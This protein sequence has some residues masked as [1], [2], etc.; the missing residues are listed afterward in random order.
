MTLELRALET[1]GI[2]YIMGDGYPMLEITW[3]LW[4]HVMGHKIIP[5]LAADRSGSCNIFV[6]TNNLPTKPSSCDGC[7]VDG[8]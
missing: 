1:N 5:Y 4:P 2:V 3:E 8:L 7:L 6:N